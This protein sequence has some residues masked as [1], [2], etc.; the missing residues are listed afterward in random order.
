MDI[1]KLKAMMKEEIKE[2]EEHGFIN[3]D[4]LINN[5]IALFFVFN[6]T[7]DGAK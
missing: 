7:N 5:L 4:T 2:F 1:L 3:Y 6:E